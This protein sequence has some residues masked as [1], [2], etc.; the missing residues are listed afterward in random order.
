M[1]IST[2][3]Y[4]KNHTQQ[5]LRLKADYTVLP[6]PPP[7]FLLKMHV[8]VCVY[9]VF[10]QIHTHSKIYKGTSVATGIKIVLFSAKN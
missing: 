4:N 1:K 6:R 5:D 8:C 10:F 7:N 9:F 2:T 3:T